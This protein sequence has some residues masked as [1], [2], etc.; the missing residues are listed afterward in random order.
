MEI[1]TICGSMKFSTEMKKVA[2]ELESTYGY[3]VLQCVYNELNKE[4]DSEMFEKLKRAHYSKID[5]SDI[6]YVVD[7][8]GY[9]GESVKN[10]IEYAK[11]HHK[12]I[13]FY[14]ENSKIL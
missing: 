13:L 2:F 11:N 9:I 5:L 8:D 10:E 1:V 12:K 14:S 4:I 6:I 7:V 3:N